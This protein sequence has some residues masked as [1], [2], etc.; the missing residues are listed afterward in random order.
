MLILRHS[1]WGVEEEE[2]AEGIDRL[3]ASCCCCWELLLLREEAPTLN[4]DSVDEAANL[5]KV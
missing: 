3:L 4:M 5:L 1:S 2:E